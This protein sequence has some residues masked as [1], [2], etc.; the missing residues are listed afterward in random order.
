MSFVSPAPDDQAH[1]D[2]YADYDATHRRG[3]RVGR[4]ELVEVLN[5]MNPK[6]DYRL[7][8]VTQFCPL[9]GKRVLDVG[10][11][12]GAM[13]TLASRL[14]AVVEGVELDQKAVDAA[15]RDLGLSGC[16][17]GTIESLPSTPAF[18]VILMMDLIEHVLDPV[19]AIREALSRLLPAGILALWTPNG[20]EMNRAT[21][22]VHL[23]VDLEHMQYFSAQ[24][25]R[26]VAER[27]G[28]SI[29]HS[30]VTGH[31]NLSA[32]GAAHHRRGCQVLTDAGRSAVK[33]IPGFRL[34]ERIR[35]RNWIDPLGDPQ[36]N[37]HLFS[38]LKKP[39]NAEATV[40]QGGRASW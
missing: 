27:F 33:S 19:S 6:K 40:V 30:G 26:S 12:R 9:R 16:R 5:G 11:G 37:Y 15:Q 28:V 39:A 23:R 21:Q 31:P 14:G 3:R 7:S 22:P 17:F 34:V 1:R 20:N 38:I 24:A 10:F 36:G 2:F 4:R 18:H 35:R 25:I 32:L 13:L 8:V 29:I